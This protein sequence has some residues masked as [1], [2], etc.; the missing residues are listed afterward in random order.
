M[1]I[2]V[3]GGS[4]DSK[5][6]T[7]RKESPLTD[8][9]PELMHLTKNVGAG[10]DAKAESSHI[11]LERTRRFIGK[12]NSVLTNGVIPSSEAEK[13]HLD[14][15]KGADKGLTDN[16]KQDHVTVCMRGFTDRHQYSRDLKDPFSSVMPD[17]QFQSWED[18]FNL[19]VKELLGNEASDSPV[20]I[21]AERDSAILKKEVDKAGKDEVEARL[22]SGFQVLAKMGIDMSD[23]SDRWGTSNPHPRWEGLQR[24]PAVHMVDRIRPE[25]IEAVYVPREFYDAVIAGVSPLHRDKI[26]AVDGKVKKYSLTVEN[27]V[28]DLS[29]PDWETP[30]RGDILRM[31]HPRGLGR[32]TNLVKRLRGKDKPLNIALHGVR[33]PTEKEVAEELATK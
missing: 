3:N 23:V 31:L 27:G 5:D 1:G 22:G 12:V 33:C 24:H 28:E 11:L 29:T 13:A 30:I 10:Q 21:L 2:E 6:A 26:R 17:K 20:G 16:W 14:A 8:A 19:Q 15:L 18:N 4:P 7:S 9:L 25:E 32:M